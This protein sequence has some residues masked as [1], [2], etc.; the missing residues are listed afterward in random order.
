M[1]KGPSEPATVVGG[2]KAS[3]F[4]GALE[5]VLVIPAKHERSVADMRLLIRDASIRCSADLQAGKC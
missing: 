1:P 2:A 5:I 4:R 3:P